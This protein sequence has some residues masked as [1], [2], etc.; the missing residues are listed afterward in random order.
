MISGPEGETGIKEDKAELDD[1]EESA[2][3]VEEEKL[4]LIFVIAKRFCSNPF[5][6]ETKE[7]EL[8]NQC[9]VAIPKMRRRTKLMREEGLAGKG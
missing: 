4:E 9:E 7:Q 6:S 1:E 3:T 2:G 8:S 5:S